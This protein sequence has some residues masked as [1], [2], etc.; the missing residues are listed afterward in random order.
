MTVMA[1][2]P[3][4]LRLD[5]SLLSPPLSTISIDC[6]EQKRSSGGSLWKN[7]S[8]PTT[9]AAF[10]DASFAGDDED[11]FCI[12][13]DIDEKYSRIGPLVSSQSLMDD[14]RSRRRSVS[15]LPKISIRNVEHIRD[16]SNEDIQTIWYTTADYQEIKA[17]NKQAVDL[18][19][20]YGVVDD[21][22]E[23]CSRGLETKEDISRRRRNKN[24]S[25]GAVMNEQ[26][27]QRMETCKGAMLPDL[28]AMLYS[29]YSFP[30]QQTAYLN[31]IRDAQD[32]GMD[33]IPV[34][35]LPAED[36]LAL[37]GGD[38]LVRMV[39]EERISSDETFLCIEDWMVE[40]FE[41]GQ[42]LAKV[43]KLRRINESMNS[44]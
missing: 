36:N 23:F 30:C 41:K 35:D 10:G 38:I 16:F 21:D 25:I 9:T 12:S 2:S 8:I 31:A 22:L 24:E 39:E 6:K 29:V 40:R 1:A 19:V 44:E 43:N 13:T 27:L 5:S 15:F 4:G 11:D 14:P 3:T 33:H 34:E 42:I 7:T 37:V 20:R 18:M 32:V 17:E 28:I 26:N